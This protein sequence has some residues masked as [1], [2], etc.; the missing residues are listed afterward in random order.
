[1]NRPHDAPR[2]P[3]P[4]D[5]RAS[6]ALAPDGSSTRAGALALAAAGALAFVM[7]PGTPAFPPGWLASFVA[8]G[9]LAGLVVALAPPVAG[10]AAHAARIAAGGAALGGLVLLAGAPTAATGIALAL[11]VALAA[12]VAVGA[13]W[14]RARISRPLAVALALALVC[15]AQL[16]TLGLAG[17]PYAPALQARQAVYARTVEPERYDFDG[18]LYLRTRALMRRG[19][20]FYPAFQQAWSEDAR[21]EG[22]IATP[23]SFREPALFELWRVLPGAS[24]TALLGWFVAFALL[25]ALAG[26]W[27]AA[28]F[29]S[30]GVALL[31]PI[32]LS[33]FFAF[34]VLADRSWFTFAEPWSAGVVVVALALLARGR[35]VASALALAVAVAFRELAILYVPVWVLAWWLGGRPRARVPALLI[36][37]GGAILPIALHVLSAPAAGSAGGLALATWLHSPGLPRLTRA[38]RHG[39]E[40]MPHGGA[41]APWLALLALGG[42]VALRER[43]ARWALAAAVAVPAAFLVAISAN[44]FDYYWGA[45]LTPVVL[46]LLPLAFARGSPAPGR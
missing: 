24:G 35:W 46:A 20:A 32:G 31:A 6:H 42:A 5:D 40:L 16:W 25:V 41:L 17:G 29:A 14:A 36:A 11:G 26:W 15:G 27:L 10:D 22:R 39:L 43:A 23:L 7:F 2:A 45:I 12:A 19:V 33:S 30:D 44:R 3:A 28:I 37:V 9:L 18:E 38:L 4:S 13:A 21:F 1:M 34:F 8:R